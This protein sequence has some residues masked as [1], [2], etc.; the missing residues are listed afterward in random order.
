MFYLQE[1]D[2]V[3]G[4]SELAQLG[5]SFLQLGDLLL[6]LAEKLLS[7]ARGRSLLSTDQLLHLRAPPL[8]GAHQLREDPLAL[9]YSRLRRELVVMEIKEKQS[10][11]GTG[12]MDLFIWV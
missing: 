2:L 11:Y 5:V 9:V 12:L 4:L 3:L 1:G 8:Y 10:G 7:L 6:Q